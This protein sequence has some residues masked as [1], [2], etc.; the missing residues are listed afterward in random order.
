LSCTTQPWAG[1]SRIDWRRRIQRRA[2]IQSIGPQRHA[3]RV[4]AE[5]MRKLAQ[6]RA[7]LWDVLLDQNTTGF[8]PNRP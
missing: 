5:M 4:V 1:G 8:D 3:D 2:H 6:D 7:R